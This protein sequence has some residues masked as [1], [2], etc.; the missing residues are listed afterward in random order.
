MTLRYLHERLGA[1]CALNG[2][3][4]KS[5]KRKDR[6]ICAGAV[7]A[8][9]F[10]FGG[11]DLRG[12]TEQAHL[13]RAKDFKTGG[14]LQSSVIELKNALQKN[15]DNAEARWLLGET[16][17]DLGQAPEAEQELVKAKELGFG[18][19]EVQVPLG[20]ALL[21]EGLYQ[22]VLSEIEA[23]PA[24]SPAS[25]SKIIAVRGEAHLGL[26]QLDQA[27]ALFAQSIDVDHSYVPGYWGLSK[28][29]GAKGNLPEA[30]AQLEKA[31]KLE[32]KNSGTWT[33]L[34]DIER[35]TS[36]QPEAEAAY[37]NALK[38][39]PD[40]LD[41]LLGRATSRITA[42]KPEEAAKDIDAVLTIAK[43]HPVANHLRGVIQYGK[44][45]YADAK[46]SFEQAL[47]VSP[48]YFPAVLWLGYTNYALKNYAQAE[49]QFAQYVTEYP[50][51]VQVQALRA[52]SQARMGGRKEAQQTLG[53][54]RNAKIEDPQS[55]SALGQT[56]MLLG[57]KDLA[58]RYFRE[59]VAKMP[60]RA[61]ARIELANALLQK[62]ENEQAIEQLQKA[63]ALSP[64]E[65]QADEQLIQ[66]LI[67]TKQFD[68]AKAAISALQARQ[69]KSP[70]PHLY[71]G[72]IAIQQN[73]ADLAEAE[74]LKAWEL[75]PDDPRAANNLA[76][77]EV[78][79]GRIE[80]A[81]N[82][83]KKVLDR[84]KE[85]L[86]TL[87]G[88]YNLELAAKRPDEARKML[89]RAAAKYPTATQPAALLAG[90]YL[91]AG[92]PSKAIEI[93]QAAAQ[94]NPNDLQLLDV[95]GI[96]Y[97]ANR[98][99]ANA[100]EMYQRLVK[101]LPNSAEANFK[102]GAAQAAL[103][104]R[105]AS[106]SFAQAL[107][108][109]PSH[110]GAKLALAQLDLLEGKNDEALRL[111]RE[112]KKEHPETVEAVLIESQALAG[113]KK[114]PEALKVVEQA[115]K[116]QPASDRLSFALAN[117][118]WRAGDKDGTRES[119]PNGWD[120]IPTTL[121]PRSARP[122]PISRTGTKVKLPGPM[123]KR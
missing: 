101:L 8:A 4:M 85:D 50:R 88:L 122:K 67:Q 40:D 37:A 75:A 10:G 69:P 77:L 116:A 52:L 86:S 108:L 104:D 44:G 73:K 62:G 7:T 3:P 121:Q 83:Y 61:E 114:L 34:G 99:P 38:Y 90:S 9:V 119:L 102:L 21:A 22:R 120:S 95:R 28:C 74:F 65:T 81:R 68:K 26:R 2:S 110:L 39:K 89:E 30:R 17:L 72:L 100:L 63:I 20:K 14:K 60:E 25:Q 94:A 46:T 24:F 11:C 71:S 49:S 107:K 57:E 112:L 41:A 66:T 113:Q 96:A 64:G 13:Q 27:C 47:A 15:P 23:N 55:L 45:N 12:D 32:E 19:E 59:V 92:Q 103:K 82:Y 117:L 118:R 76:A 42:N 1:T 111:A 58:A 123:R 31:L 54:L 78:R 56:H 51:V 106:A 115:Q 105:A 109:E 97:L 16:Y 98:D 29:A 5:M 91:K 35:F 84:G 87:M 53:L 70:A 36:H 80:E 43:A 6:W 93:T 79:K 48:G 33:M 18:E